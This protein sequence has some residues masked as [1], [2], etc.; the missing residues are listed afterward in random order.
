MAGFTGADEEM[1]LL[2]TVRNSGI[3]RTDPPR[4]RVYCLLVWEFRFNVVVFG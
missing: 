3:G 4:I 1:D 2:E